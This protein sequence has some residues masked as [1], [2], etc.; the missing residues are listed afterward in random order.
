MNQIN[1]LHL[2]LTMLKED[3]PIKSGTYEFLIPKCFWTSGKSLWET[4]PV[5]FL[6]QSGVGG[7]F[8]G[9]ENGTLG[10]R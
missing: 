6:K 2:P 10:N 1:N 3:C 4:P 8:F 9:E 7:I 5:M